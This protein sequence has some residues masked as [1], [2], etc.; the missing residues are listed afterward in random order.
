MAKKETKSKG[1]KAKKKGAAKKHRA[2]AEGTGNE[3][4]LSVLEGEMKSVIRN[5]FLNRGH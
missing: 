5:A 3:A 4:A 2:P 1:T